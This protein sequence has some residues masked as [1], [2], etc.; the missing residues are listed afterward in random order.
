MRNTELMTDWQ[1][2]L[3]TQATGGGAHLSHVGT[4]R[5]YARVQPASNGDISVALEWGEGDFRRY[6]RNPA[7]V[8]DST[9]NGTWRLIDLGLV[10]LSR[11]PQGTQRWEGRIVAKSTQIGDDIDVDWLALVPVAEGSGTAS[12]VIRQFTSTAFAARDEFNQT[13][14]ALSGKTL[15]VGGTWGGAGDA[16]DFNVTGTGTVTRTAVTDASSETGRY[17]LAGATTYGA[18]SVAGSLTVA[19]NSLAAGAGFSF[20][21]FARYVDTNNWLMARL[22]V[23]AFGTADVRV[24]KRVAGVT[25]ILASQS[26]SINQNNLPRRITL[27]ADTAGNYSVWHTAAGAAAGEPLLTGTD[28]VLA[29]AGALATGRIGMYDAFTNSGAWTRTYDDF[30]A[31]VPPAQDAAVYASQSIEVRHNAVLREDS[32]GSFWQTSSSYEGDYLA[33]PPSGAEARTV[34]M[35]VKASRSKPLDGA[36]SATDD[37]SARLFVTPRYL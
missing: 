17:A 32:T 10:T 15:P 19:S 4:F 24:E 29:T 2:V 18:I 21:V 34:R 14:G 31:S 20:G 1:A 33:V 12:S 37:V 22:M 28:S 36:D 27:N 3:S 23:T 35:I 7:K 11:V 25:S 9:M 6:T 26:V 16:D 30:V 8:I 13:A 5:V